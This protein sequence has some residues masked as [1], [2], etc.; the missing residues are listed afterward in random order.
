MSTETAMGAL[1]IALSAPARTIKIEF[2]GGEPLL[3]FPL[4]KQIVAA[5]IEQ[6]PAEKNIEFVIATNLALLND[7][8]LDFCREHSVLLSTS[9]DG[10]ADIH[11]R[12]RPRPGGNSHELAVAGIRRAQAALGPCAQQP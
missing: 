9:L 6:K 7:E 3:N 1:R 5:A 2:Q 12:N 8:V 4:I 11:N 10:P